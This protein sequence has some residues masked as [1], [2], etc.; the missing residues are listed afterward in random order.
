M[1]YPDD[2]V[3]G[4][5]ASFL[6]AKRAVRIA[7]HRKKFPGGPVDLSDNPTMRPP[8]ASPKSF[9]DEDI[10]TSR[11]SMDMAETLA[12]AF[13]GRD[14]RRID[15]GHPTVIITCPIKGP[16]SEIRAPTS[17]SIPYNPAFIICVVYEIPREFI[18][19]IVASWF[20]NL[21]VSEPLDGGLKRALAVAQLCRCCNSPA[22][23][24][25]ASHGRAGIYSPQHEREI[26]CIAIESR[27]FQIGRI[28]EPRI[29][30]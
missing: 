22:Y 24:T 28:I 27:V 5:S 7:F 8:P 12:P 21:V 10:A 13:D 1:R 20:Q 4:R 17:P 23:T 26:R 25:R 14:A 2:R 16:T 29:F 30:E 6:L 9:H 18:E 19:V 11:P 15:P 3:I